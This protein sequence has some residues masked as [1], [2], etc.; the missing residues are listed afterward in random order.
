MQAESVDF[1]DIKAYLNV[2]EDNEDHLNHLPNKPNHEKGQN[3]LR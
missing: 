3:K 2:N 1:K